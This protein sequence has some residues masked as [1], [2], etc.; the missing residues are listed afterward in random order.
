MD[1]IR[2]RDYEDMSL[3]AAGIVADLIRKKPDAVL[4]LATGSSPIGLYK[5]LIDMYQ[6]GELDMSGVTTANLDEYVGLSPDNE[7]S[8]R[9][10]MDHYL[11]DHVNIDKAR[12]FV[13]DGMAEDADAEC[14]RYEALL[15]KIGE[16]DLQ[17][18][19]LGL[20]G[21]IGFNEPSEAFSD[22]TCCVEL[23]QSTIEANKRFFSS[24]EEVPGKAYT[25]GIGTIMRAKKILMV[26][27]GEAKADILEKVIRGPVCP[28]VP[29]SILRFHRYVTI[30][31]DEAALSKCL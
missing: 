27:N 7:Q 6:R 23:D 29:A 13:P 8:Y 22:V 20:D 26:V 3:K 1:I 31:A 5:A 9:Y 15:S 18:L 17:L 12:T 4:G 10:F 16:R 30:V 28:G 21:H 25:M 24:A 14:R 2:A 11:F 19:G